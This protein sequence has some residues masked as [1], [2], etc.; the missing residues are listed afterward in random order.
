[1][2]PLA[3][4]FTKPQMRLISMIGMGVLVGTS[5]IVI[6]PEGIETLYR[7]SSLSDRHHEHEESFAPDHEKPSPHAYIGISLITG[8]ILMYLIDTLPPLISHIRSPASSPTYIA[9]NNLSSSNT[10]SSA[11]GSSA[12]PSSYSTTTGLVIHA[13]A[14]GIALGASSTASNVA[15]ETII[16]VAIMLHKAPAAFGLSAV[17][18]KKGLG[19]RQARMHLAVFSLA[20]PAGALGTWVIINLLGGGV[21]KVGMQWWSGILLL[22]SGG[23]FLYVATH[24]MQNNA[25]GSHSGD[26]ARDEGDGYLSPLPPP[27]RR[28]RREGPSVL[29][30]AAAVFGMLIPLLTQVGHHGQ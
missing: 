17:L 27:N 11:S 2:L 15:L 28:D 23:T 16:F 29:D 12:P 13:C 14:D 25:S 8:F 9:L 6:I 18:L 24:T 20:A 3:I 4:S 5:L 1:M 30:T 7:V 10:S 22:F 19:K 26:H 21:D